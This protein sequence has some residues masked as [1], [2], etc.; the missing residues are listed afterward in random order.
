MFNLISKLKSRKG[1]NKFVPQP[2]ANKLDRIKSLNALGVPISLV[3]D[4]GVQDATHDLISALPDKHHHLFEPV[5]LWHPKIK[6]NYS[7]VKHSLHPVALGSENGNAWLIQS[8]LK[9]DGIATHAT[10]ASKPARPDYLNIVN[11]DKIFVHQLDD[12]AHLFDRNYLLKIDVDG[13]EIDILQGAK[14]CLQNAS[15]IIIEADYSSLAQR[16]LLLEQSGFQLIDIIDR[17]MYG[18]VLW[19]CDLVYLRND[20]MNETLRPPFFKPEAWRPLP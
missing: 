14:C 8:A 12:Y 19:Q 20:L 2:V 7:L 6:E 13:K 1:P 15:I 5:K 11:C 3:V 16:G 18:E 17:I 9:G 4:V 10:I